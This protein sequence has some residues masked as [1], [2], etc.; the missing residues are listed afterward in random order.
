MVHL[1]TLLDCPTYAIRQAMVGV[2]GSLIEHTSQQTFYDVLLERLRDKNSF[3]RS[4]VIKAVQKISR[5]DLFNAGFLEFNNSQKIFIPPDLRNEIFAM[6]AG[7]LNDTAA[8]VRTNAIK[9]LTVM[10]QTAPYTAFKR[11]EG[12]INKELFEARLA[13]VEAAIK[14]FIANAGYARGRRGY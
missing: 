11:D 8:V 3:V 10:V 4:S 1:K 6:V 2:L 12:K 14:V 7:R 9:C 5:F 13:E